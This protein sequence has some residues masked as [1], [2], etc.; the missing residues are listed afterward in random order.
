MPSIKIC[1]MGEKKDI[2]RFLKLLELWYG[3]IFT[4]GPYKDM[5]SP[6]YKAYVNIR[7]PHNEE[8]RLGR[9]LKPRILM[10]WKARSNE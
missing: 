6:R 4:T 3:E 1:V 2:I 5:R 7:I 9:Y 8:E 10:E